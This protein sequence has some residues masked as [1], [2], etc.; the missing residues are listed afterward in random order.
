[1]YWLLIGLIPKLSYPIFYERCQLSIKIQFES[2]VKILKSQVG[3]LD[4]DV[5]RLE[6]ARSLDV[7]ILKEKAF[8]LVED[9]RTLK[10]ECVR[11]LDQMYPLTKFDPSNPLTQETFGALEKISEIQ[12][13]ADP[14]FRG[15]PDPCSIFTG[16]WITTKIQFGH[17]HPLTPR[18]TGLAQNKIHRFLP[19]NKSAI[20]VVVA[21]AAAF[22][23]I[24]KFS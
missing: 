16:D 5:H 10:L 19:T 3:T 21:A 9:T 14:F 22:F 23:L 8:Q 4:N 1:M 20:L 13:H 15:T 6:K 24:K 18:E 11:L 12:Q 7:K 17:Q 2:Q